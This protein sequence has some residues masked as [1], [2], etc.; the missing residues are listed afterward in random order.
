MTI[1]QL[2]IRAKGYFNN[3]KATGNT[4][5]WKKGMKAFNEILKRQGKHYA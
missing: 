3:F 5:Y 2:K 4:D 1:E